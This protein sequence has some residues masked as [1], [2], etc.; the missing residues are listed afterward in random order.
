[1]YVCMYGWMDVCIDGWMDVWM[2]G[3]ATNNSNNPIINEWKQK[4]LKSTAI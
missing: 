2:D 4:G 1:M 3:R